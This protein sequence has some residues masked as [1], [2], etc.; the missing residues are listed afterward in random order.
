MPPTLPS[1]TPLRSSIQRC[2]PSLSPTTHSAQIT[3]RNSA[4][5]PSNTRCLPPAAISAAPATAI[6]DRCLELGNPFSSS[7]V[8]S[9]GDEAPESTSPVESP[10]AECLCWL[11]AGEDSLNLGDAHQ[12]AGEPCALTRLSPR[13]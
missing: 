1:T 2:F 11:H 5:L 4:T 6:S 8:S 9:E 3:S 13:K 7:Y 10:P 12:K